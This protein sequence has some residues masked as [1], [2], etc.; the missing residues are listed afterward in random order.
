[1]KYILFLSSVFLLFSC[2]S[3]AS[4]D[5]EGPDVESSGIVPGAN[6]LIGYADKLDEL[7]TLDIA[8]EVAALPEDGAETNYNR[9]MKKTEYHSVAYMWKSDRKRTI[10]VG[11][12]SMEVPKSNRV[13]LN[14]IKNIKREHFDMS[15]RK[16]TDED[17]AKMNKMI[18]NALEGKSDNKKINE[19]LKKLDDMGVDKQTQKQAT[20]AMTGMIG[21]VA[22]AYSPVAGIGEAASWNSV[23][24]SLYVY[25]GGV[26]LAVT[27]DLSEDEQVNK[28]KAI[29]LMKTLMAR[30]K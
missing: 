13:E 19:R 27:V 8:A 18:D 14:G 23:E 6:C 1:M 29:G 10:N 20:G 4:S 3:N 15:R 21:Q 16:A 30:C 24:N 26:E 9:V 22:K 5:L 28:N 2:G 25:T 11:G 17:L 7:L 12:H